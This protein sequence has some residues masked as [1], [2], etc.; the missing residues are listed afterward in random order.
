MSQEVTGK[1]EVVGHFEVAT[2]GAVVV[3]HLRD[4]FVKVGDKVHPPNSSVTWTIK[5]VEFV[6][7]CSEPTLG[8]LFYGHSKK[9]KVEAAFPIGSLMDI[10]GS[11]DS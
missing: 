1:F 5:G 8:I 6:D 7:R 11:R 3:G 10:Y 4:G 9:D 2:R